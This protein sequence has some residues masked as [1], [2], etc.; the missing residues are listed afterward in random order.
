M[1]KQYATNDYKKIK[2]EHT[3][4][5]GEWIWYNFIEKGL[6]MD[7]FKKFCP[8]TTDTLMQIDSLMTGTPFSYTFFSTMKPGT[9]INSH[10]GPWNIR[11]RWHLPIAVPD[12]SSAFIRVGGE[13]RLW[14]EGEPILFD[15][16]YEHEAWNISKDQERAI[17][18]ID[19]WHPELTHQE[20]VGNIL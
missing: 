19:V 7:N 18:L 14:K 11:L 16:S 4:N 12:D 10:Y 20:I 5:E 15:D 6:V 8:K 17:L 1:H 2:D 9:I 13:T 3:L